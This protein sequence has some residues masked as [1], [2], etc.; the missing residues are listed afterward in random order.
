VHENKTLI[1]CKLDSPVSFWFV[2]LHTVI[3]VNPT[4]GDKH[5]KTL[6]TLAEYRRR[7]RG[8]IWFG[9]FLELQSNSHQD[10]TVHVGDDFQIT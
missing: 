7:P 9:V 5:G 1:L 6:K 8:Q 3:D 10:F 4:T 2:N